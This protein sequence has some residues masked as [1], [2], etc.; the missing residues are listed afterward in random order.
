MNEVVLQYI[1][2]I[3]P[4]QIARNL[5]IK[6]T[7]VDRYIEDW[8]NSAVGMDIMRDRVEELIAA[9]DEHYS[10]LITKAY[11]VIAE[12]DTPDDNRKETMTRS[13]MLS[14]KMS[15][16]KTI[17]DLE[18]KRIDLMQKSGMLEAAD[19]GDLLADM[20]LQ[21]ENVMNILEEHLCPTCNQTI[22]TALAQKNGS[23]V[24]LND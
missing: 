14:Q 19:N 11:E 2:N 4:M 12:V 17:A 23:V 1:K 10:V 18:A 13:Q 20:E 15:A 5:G 9:T 24:V 6:R 7:E 3:K 21:L 8:K 16:I 22:L